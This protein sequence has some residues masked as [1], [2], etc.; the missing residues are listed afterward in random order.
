VGVPCLFCTGAAFEV[1]EGMVHISGWVEL[2]A[3]DGVTERRLMARIVIPCDPAR[4]LSRN[5]NRA[6]RRRSH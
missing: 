2:Q 6:L 3:V 1:R 5:M 4:H